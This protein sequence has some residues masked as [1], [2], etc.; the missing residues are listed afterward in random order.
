MKVG[1][2]SE[3]HHP[4]HGLRYCIYETSVRGYETS[5]CFYSKKGL[6]FLCLNIDSYTCQFISHHPLLYNSFSLS[7]L[8]NSNELYN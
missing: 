6:E 2:S 8:G 7:M 5:K 3:N 1:R 4:A